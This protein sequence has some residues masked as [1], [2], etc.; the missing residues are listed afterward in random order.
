VAMVELG[1]RLAIER[2]RTVTL[3]LKLARWSSIPTE[4]WDRRRRAASASRRAS[5]SGSSS[6]RADWEI[7][8]AGQTVHYKQVAFE[9]VTDGSEKRIT[10]TI[11]ATL[12]DFRIDPPSLLTLPVK[13]EIPVRIDMTWSSQ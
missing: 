10:G 8:F 2:A 6:I 11:P 7:Q 4:G 1:T 12:T 13:N 3:H 9:L 5:V